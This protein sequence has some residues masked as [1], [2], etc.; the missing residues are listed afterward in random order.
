MCKILGGQLL[1]VDGA[2][3]DQFVSSQVKISG[4]KI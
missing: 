1:E 2:A 3:E 4:S